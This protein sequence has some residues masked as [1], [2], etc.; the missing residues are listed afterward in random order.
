M[1]Y[2]HTLKYCSVFFS[3]SLPTL[4]TAQKETKDIWTQA[5]TINPHWPPQ[6]R[7]FFDFSLRNLFSFFSFSFFYFFSPVSSCAD[8]FGDIYN[9][10]VCFWFLAFYD[11]YFSFV[12]FWFF[13]LWVKDTQGLTWERC[14]KAYIILSTLKSKTE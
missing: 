3:P 8:W 7:Q 6:W 4:Y 5:V 12:W 11:S 10:H 1:C 9:I 14:E 13:V 2:I